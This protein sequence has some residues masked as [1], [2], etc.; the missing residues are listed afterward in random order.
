[1]SNTFLLEQSTCHTPAQRASISEQNPTPSIQGIRGPLAQSEGS[2]ERPSMIH[3]E[4]DPNG[5]SAKEAGSK[6]DAGKV[7]VVRGAIRYFPEALKAVAHVSELGAKKYA[8]DGWR[9]VPDGINRYT[10]ALGRHLLHD[11]FATDSGPG[12]LGDDVLHYAQVAW[13]A[14]AALELIILERDKK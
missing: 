4:S 14:L 12:G 3:S 1:M 2:Y 10:G 11:P 9:T 8:W 7:N 13:N 6:L 5:K